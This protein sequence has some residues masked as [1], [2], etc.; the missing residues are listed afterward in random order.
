MHLSTRVRHR[1]T[2]ATP[3]QGMCLYC[4]VFESS[5][6]FIFQCPAY[7][8]EWYGML[9]SI[10]SNVVE[11][12]FSL[13][14]WDHDFAFYLDLGDHDDHFNKPFLKYLKQAWTIRSEL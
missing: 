4:S 11:E 8:T 2:Q 6:H 3:G 10:K 1:P 12:V 7:N 5:K 9:V 14:I 13:F